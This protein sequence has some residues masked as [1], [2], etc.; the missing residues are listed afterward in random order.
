M[1]EK[2]NEINVKN[3]EKG[4]LYLSNTFCVFNIIIILG[5][6][7]IIRSKNKK[8]RV[9]KL[10]LIGAIITDLL[11]LFIF[12]IL[13]LLDNS[14]IREFVFSIFGSIEF[15]LFLS[16][17]YQIFYITKISKPPN[18]IELINPNQISLLLFLII[19]SYQKFPFI[20]NELMNFIL[21]T[22]I[23]MYL[24]F[25][26]KYFKN[27]LTKIS[28]N[29]L[30][31]NI[32]YIKI[33]FYLKRMNILCFILIFLFN[34]I[35][36]LLLFLNHEIYKLYIEIVLIIIIYTLKYA[37]FIYFPLIIYSLNNNYFYTDEENIEIIQK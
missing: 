29:I 26:Y 21:Y 32:E 1:N 16:F 12:N 17:I 4:Y 2:I 33:Y 13:K 37:V 15:Y 27:T 25:L 20:Y 7:F 8:I 6:S 22:I 28:I 19:F 23:F 24:I 36:I 30:P 10:K 31:K 14:I 11:I 9:L 18:K 35:K 34:G 3:F 5:I